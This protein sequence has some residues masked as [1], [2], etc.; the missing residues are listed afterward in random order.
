MRLAIVWSL[1]I[2]L[3]CA[4]QALTGCGTIPMEDCERRCWSQELHDSV[5]AECAEVPVTDYTSPGKCE[6]AE[7][8]RYHGCRSRC[9]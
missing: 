4:G 5:L 7:N 8:I 3:A 2:L 6:L 9:E 1:M